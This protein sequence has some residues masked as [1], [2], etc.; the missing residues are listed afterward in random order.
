MIT[1]MRQVGS[2]SFDLVME[3]ELTVIGTGTAPYPVTTRQAI[4]QLQASQLR[5][6]QTLQAAVDCS[7]PDAV[8]LDL[9]SL[10]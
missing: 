8:W 3:F 6:G 1:G 2:A 5:P 7:N 4:S 10:R 9:A